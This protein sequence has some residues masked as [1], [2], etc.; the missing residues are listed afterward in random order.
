MRCA[1]CEVESK[2]AAGGWL[3]LQYEDPEGVEESEF[4]LF[5]PACA[6]REFG[7]CRRP[8]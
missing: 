1:E 8:V 2:D 3:A 4:L 6:K 5:C 7:W